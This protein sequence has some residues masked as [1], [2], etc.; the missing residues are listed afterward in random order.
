MERNEWLG[1][2]E[3]TADKVFVHLP[4]RFT[5]ENLREE[6]IFGGIKLVDDAKLWNTGIN[7]ILKAWLKEGRI[8]KGAAVRSSRRAAAGR[9]IWSYHKVDAAKQGS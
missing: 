7:R 1:M 6:T 8:R 3:Q 4:A 9:L 5:S 2:F